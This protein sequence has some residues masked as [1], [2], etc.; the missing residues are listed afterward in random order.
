MSEN[1]SLAVSIA[2]HNRKE[3]LRRTLEALRQL[4]PRPDEIIVCA[5]TCRDGTEAMLRAEFPEVTVLV[6]EVSLGSIGSRDRIIATSRSDLLLTL[7]DD[8]YPCEPDF[9][10]RVKALFAADPTLGVVTFPQ[11]SDE[12][13]E[14]LTQED[15]GPS[16]EVGTYTSSGAV[17]RK[18]LYERLGRFPLFF[19]HAYEEPDFA[20][21]CMSAG[22]RNICCTALTVRHHYTNVMR[23]EMR[24]H[25]RHARNEL[26][27]TLMRAPWWAVPFMLPYRVFSQM[28]YAARR[29]V[30]WALRE[31]VWWWQAL[32]GLGKACGA[33]AP[34][35]WAT[36]R[37]WIALIRAQQPLPPGDPLVAPNLLS[38]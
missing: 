11:R 20:L 27:S 15:F 34:V 22:H 16:T 37:R 3:D 32:G 38:K 24:T 31:P 33:R 18:A 29:G 1:L 7:D 9:I 36:Y 23:N 21:R 5:D 28:R 19:F 10:A 8:S 4:Q 25:H 12:F 26:W 17:F 30:G 35:D 2:T 6:N 13:P 14:T